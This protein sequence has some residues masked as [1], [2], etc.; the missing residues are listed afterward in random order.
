MEIKQGSEAA[1]LESSDYMRLFKRPVVNPDI[2]NLETAYYAECEQYERQ[3]WGL[4]VICALVFL[5]RL[6]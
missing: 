5:A 1:S 3:L 6:I 2:L 4:I